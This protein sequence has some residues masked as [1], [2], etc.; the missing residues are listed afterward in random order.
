MKYNFRSSLFFPVWKGNGKWT[1]HRSITTSAAMR[2]LY[3]SIRALVWWFALFF[4]VYKLF[5]GVP[6]V[7][8]WTNARLYG[9]EWTSVGGSCFL[10]RMRI[11]TLLLTL[12]KSWIQRRFPW[13]P[14]RL[15]SVRGGFVFH[16][17]AASCHFSRSWWTV[18]C[19]RDLF[20]QCSWWSSLVVFLYVTL[21]KRVFPF[22]SSL[23]TS[24][25][26]YP[27]SGHRRRTE[28]VAPI[29]RAHNAVKLQV[30]V[31][32]SGKSTTEGKVEQGACVKR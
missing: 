19:F 7:W 27:T 6:R 25:F 30:S 3:R 14:R 9:A 12:R 21:N 28:M 20:Y 24:L 2:A 4:L 26:V 10:P 29:P 17:G 15:E 1:T 32:N 31:R 8:R 5:W 22:L 16:R 11:S 23:R 18:V 13:D